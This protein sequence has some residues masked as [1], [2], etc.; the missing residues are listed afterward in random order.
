MP[1]T[2][3]CEL[4]R[5][6]LCNLC[7]LISAFAILTYSVA[8]AQ[9]AKPDSASALVAGA[10]RPGSVQQ[11]ASPLTEADLT[12]F[13]DILVPFQLKSGGIAG[14]TVVVVAK[15]KVLFAKGYG[16]RDVAKKQPVSAEETMFRPGSVS[17]LFTW[18]AVMQLV[19]QGKLDLDRNVND[20]LDFTIPATFPKPITLRTLMTHTAGFEE[21]YKD[22]F[23]ESPADLRSTANYVKKHLP[24]RLFSPGATVAYSN[25]GATLAGY[26]VER[27][28]GIRFEE[29]VEKFIFEPLNMSHSTFYQPLPASLEP[30]MSKTYRTA[31]GMP[32]QFTICQTISAG[33][34]SSSAGDMA[35]FMIAHLQDGAY[36]GTRILKPETSRMMHA[37]QFSSSDSVNGFALGFY[38]ESRNGLRIIGHAGDISHFHS[39]LHLIPEENF[40]LFVSYN[41]DGVNPGS[42]RGELWDAFLNR[43]FPYETPT[44]ATLVSAPKDAQALVGG[45]MVSRRSDDSILRYS[46][47]QGEEHVRSSPDGIISLDSV[48]D[49]SGQ[50]KRWREIAPWLY[51]EIGGQDRLQFYRDRRGRITIATDF[52]VFVYQRARFWDDEHVNLFTAFAVLGVFGLAVVLWPVSALLRRHYQRPLNLPATDR[53]SRL[54]T[55]LVCLVD[56]FALAIWMYA[57]ASSLPLNATK[58]D[59]V[60]RLIQSINVLGVACAL[61]VVY[62]CWHAWHNSSQ[63]IWSK[64]GETLILFACFGY[65]ALV[66]N[67]NVLSFSLQY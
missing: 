48:K 63:S 55:R 5:S 60:W 51:R 40:G 41:S 54:L 24:R 46:M 39:A 56:F 25:Y 16:Y 49:F 21:T 2:H 52:P 65:I 57:F 8:G 50:P 66:W 23:L 37:H 31:S 38:E 17:K 15:G 36:A 44:I 18:T 1:S 45:Y 26:I 53:R 30:L 42:G 22:V 10:L 3:T 4:W 29:Y 11:A 43:Y 47:I 34:L 27:A 61:L 28:S 67:W 64:V 32:G 13:F 20:Y 35:K 7:N 59:W 19:E 62:N 6:Q 9:P 12:E 58:D 33:A 14:A